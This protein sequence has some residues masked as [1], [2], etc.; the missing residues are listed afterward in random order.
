MP[1]TS[2]SNQLTASDNLRSGGDLYPTKGDDDDHHSESDSEDEEEPAPKRRRGK[3]KPRHEAPLPPGEAAAPQTSGRKQRVEWRLYYPAQLTYMVS[4]IAE[5]LPKK[6]KKATAFVTDVANYMVDGHH[7]DWTIPEKYRL[8][9]TK[10]REMTDG[11]KRIV[12]RCNTSD[13]RS[14]LTICQI[15]NW[16]LVSQ[17]P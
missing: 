7:F 3:A 10:L 17:C 16:A 9:N 2:E 15:V 6:H 11:D 12:S 5:Y 8:A 13:T 4:Q 1:S 14:Q